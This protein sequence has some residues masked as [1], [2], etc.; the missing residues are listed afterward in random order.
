MNSYLQNIAQVFAQQ[1]GTELSKYTFVFP[2]HRAGLFFRKHLGKAINQ[3][4]F[5]PKIITI[6]ECFASL[7]DLRVTDQ[8]TLLLRLYKIYSQQRNNAEPLE[9]FIHWG[10]MML[11]DF[12]EIDNH[13]IQDVKSLYALVEDIHDIDVHFSALSPKQINAI[14]NFWGEFH[15]S[16]AN[17]QDSHMHKQFIRTWQ[18]LYPL[19]TGLQESLLEDQLAYEGLLHRQ[20]IAHWEE[21]PIE[22]FSQQYVFIGFNATTESE[23]RLMLELQKM[24]RADFYFDYQDQILQD[25]QN[26]A[27]RFMAGN[28]LVFRSRYKL[29][30]APT[31]NQLQDKDITL[32]TVSSSVSQ[33]HQIHEILS[34][35]KESIT[36]WTRTAVVLPNEELL[37]PLLHT[38]PDGIDK[39]NVTMGYP[40]RAT[41]SFMLI[42]YP[43]QYII[44]MPQDGHEFIQRIRK[45]LQAMRNN[46]NSESIYQMLKIVDLLEQAMY[47]NTDIQFA[48][49]AIQQLLKMLTMEMTIPYTGEPLEGLQIMGVLETRALEFDNII[50]ADFNDDIYPGRSR[51]NSFIP[52]T[53]RRGFDLPT[54]ERQDAIFA[55]NFYRMLTHAKNIWFIANTHADEQR[56]GELSRYYYQ[57]LWQYQVPIKHIIIN[58]KLLSNIPQR[59][60]ISK[61][62]DTLDI[63]SKYFTT[64]PQKR[65]LSATALGEYLRCQKSFYYKYVENIHDKEE[66]ESV[67]ISNKTF[68][69]VYHEI[70]QYLYTPLEGKIVLEADIEALKRDVYND[71]YWS[72]L[73]PLTKLQGDELAEKVIRNCVYTT[74]EHDLNLVPF[75]YY[76]SELGTLRTLE[77]PS[78]KE[79]L[80]FF[81]KIDRIDVKNDCMRIIDYKTGSATLDFTSMSEIFGR[82]KNTEDEELSI[83]NEG[84]RYIL[85]TLLYCWLL[86]GDKRIQVLQE[87]HANALGVSP[88]I[89]S[90]RQLNDESKPTYL[91][92]KGE[93]VLYT[94]DIADEFINQLTELIEEIYNPDLPFYPTQDM[95]KCEGCYLSEICLITKEKE[96]A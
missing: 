12:S 83:R 5:A 57:L 41:S 89:Y 8:L 44:P 14:K 47:S 46:T 78:L 70:M 67:S 17:N 32:V 48:V 69:E 43:E 61:T 20:V 55:Y 66:D 58:D 18:L 35:F 6:N 73:E 51:N 10:K 2:N 22:R 87:K 77:I 91:H 34:T 38:I 60:P 30:E 36:D 84:N 75:E 80:S 65:S 39:V 68:G 15:Q 26:A 81:G 64:S 3:P 1:V 90:V 16:S 7:S 76:K 49:E 54:I 74:L 19:Y 40:L 52:Y 9:Q 4:I 50:I 95:R 63:L 85:Q 59:L 56:S 88:G 23:H 86:E 82:S 31:N 79:E 25:P 94:R 24:N 93:E 13:L 71:Q 27:S 96:D 28:Q 45:E 29:P 53:L 21:I 11:A 92:K 62:Q 42:A 72:N 33:T 37:I